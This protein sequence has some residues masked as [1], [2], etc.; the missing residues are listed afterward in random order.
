MTTSN[1][2]VDSSQYDDLKHHIQSL[3]PDVTF[4]NNFYLI[5]D[6][7]TQL[8]KNKIN[9]VECGVFNGGTLLPVTIFCNGTDKEVNITGIDSFEGFPEGYTS[10]DYD[11][12]NTFKTQLD[13]GEITADNYSKA[14]ARCKGNTDTFTSTDYFDIAESKAFE[15]ANDTP[16]VSLIKGY[17]SDVLPSYNEDIDILFLDCDLY[18]SYLDCLNN[19]YEKVVTGGTIIFDEY[20]SHKYPGARQAVNEFFDGR[21]DGTFEKYMSPDDYERWCWVKK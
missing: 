20:Y 16:N 19:L 21:N 1:F 11:D 3:Y 15:F 13:A 17:F 6:K 5:C 8:Q 14:E 10:N 18:S 12:F 9:Y 2:S 4:V 7:I